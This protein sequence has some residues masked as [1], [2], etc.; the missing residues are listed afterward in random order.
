MKFNYGLTIAYD[1]TKFSGI[2]YQKDQITVQQKIEEA[3]EILFKKKI[4]IVVAGR[5]DAGVHATGQVISFRTPIPILDQEKFIRSI[6]ALAGPYISVIKFHQLPIHFHARFDCIAREYEYLIYAGKKVPIFLKNQIWHIEEEINLFSIKEELKD[7]LGEKDFK[8]FAKRTN[9]NTVRYIEYIQ[10]EQ[11]NDPFLDLPL[12]SI[13]IRGNAFLHNMIRI[14]VGTIVDRIQNRISLSLKEILES[15]DR[16]KAGQTAPAE[17]LYFKN[18]YYPNVEDLYN[19]G[20]NLLEAYPIFG[21]SY[22]KNQLQNK[23][24]LETSTKII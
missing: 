20:L 10:I 23:I 24:R 5:T 11:K 19:T 15:K 12:Y 22:Y 21:A 3:L 1:G 13:R 6:H 9:E 17:G 18:A 4:R 7:I 2:Q 8:A 14:L 16:K